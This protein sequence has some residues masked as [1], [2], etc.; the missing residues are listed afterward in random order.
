MSKKK[1]TVLQPLG[2][3]V[4]LKPLDTKGE[5]KTDS[6]I[7]LPSGMNDDKG[8]KRAQV[9]AVGPG[10][11]DDGDLIP[12]GVKEGAQVLYN[13]G[14]EITIDGEEYILVNEAN[15]LAIIK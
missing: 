3:R 6:G 8:A 12:V 11:Y 2:D 13:W 5:A 14:D 15:I 9:I 4:L 10:R 7:I 1:E